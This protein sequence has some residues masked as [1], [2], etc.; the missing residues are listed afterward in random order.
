VG[1]WVDTDGGAATSTVVG[2]SVVP[3]VRA[4]VGAEVGDRDG[5]VLG[6]DEGA[7]VGTAVGTAAGCSVGTDEGAGV[8]AA[9]GTAVG[10][11]VGTDEGAAVG[12]S[13]GA[14]VGD[15][16]AVVGA[17][18]GWR[19]LNAHPTAP[20]GRM[21]LESFGRCRSLANTGSDP[22]ADGTYPC[23]RVKT[24]RICAGTKSSGDAEETRHSPY[25]EYVM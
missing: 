15:V 7:G 23:C 22:A 13:V 9:V 4:V 25:G 3:A 12:R 1:C 2:D 21:I 18:L 6:T 14:A 5:A 17:K 8:G 11:L 10:C 16:G 24:N 19:G 20:S